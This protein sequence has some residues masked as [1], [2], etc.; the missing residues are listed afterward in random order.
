MPLIDHWKTGISIIPH[1]MNTDTI[2]R[3]L[4]KS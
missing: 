3:V 1:V 4:I 2:Q